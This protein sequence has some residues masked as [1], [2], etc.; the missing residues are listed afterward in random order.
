M[1]DVTLEGGDISFVGAFDF[2]HVARTEIVDAFHGAEHAALGIFRAQAHEI[3]VIE[4]VVVFG[5]R[6]G[7]ARDAPRRR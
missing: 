4:L 3:G 1:K 2:D 7:I 6:Q 5:R